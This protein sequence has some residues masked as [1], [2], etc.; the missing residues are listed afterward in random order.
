MNFCKVGA[1]AFCIAAQV[2]NSGSM[3]PTSD[4]PSKT[5]KFSGSALY[6]QPAY[7]AYA[8][9]NERTSTDQSG[10]NAQS[11]GTMPGY[12]W[13]FFL[14]SSYGFKPGTDVNLKF[15]YFDDAT[16]SY[17]ALT[18]GGT[19]WQN[20]FTRWVSVNFELGRELNIGDF[21]DVRIHGGVQYARINAKVLY[22]QVID[23]TN[24]YGGLGVSGPLSGDVQTTYNG[25]GPRIGADLGYQLSSFWEKLSGL[26]VYTN[27]AVG[28]L[29]G[30]NSYK[31]NGVSNSAILSG[32]SSRKVNNVVPEVDIKLGLDYLV[33]FAKGDLKF[34]A[35]WLWVDYIS[36]LNWSRIGA[37]GEVSF[38]GLYFGAKW[39]GN[40]V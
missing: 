28:L 1:L 39:K 30:K 27:G 37:N 3:G 13:G 38:Q 8:W 10:N 6:L 7:P 14:E 9:S 24:D 40:I 16:R 2:A 34:D 17:D 23:S 26:H 12:D 5:W 4:T 25:F 20:F 36:A 11:Y 19:G 15:Y 22:S 29:A 35:G 18:R 33:P 21:S 31:S 32:T